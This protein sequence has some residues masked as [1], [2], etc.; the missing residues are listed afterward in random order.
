MSLKIRVFGWRN[1]PLD[2]ITRIEQ[3]FRELG[4][5]V[6][7]GDCDLI[8][9]HDSSQYEEAIK[10]LHCCSSKTKLF[11]KVLDVPAH[12]PNYD[13]EKTREILKQADKVLANSFFVQNQIQKYFNLD[14]Y[15]VYETA[16]QVPV[17]ENRGNR[18][19]FFFAGRACD[20]NKRFYLIKSV[21]NK[22][23]LSPNL[24]ATAGP[25]NPG[26]GQYFGIVTDEL[27]F[28]LYNNSYFTALPS[29]VEGVGLP[30][31]EAVMCERIPIV[32]NDNLTALELLPAEFCV[33][34]TTEAIAEY[35]T[36]LYENPL[37]YVF[38][39]KRIKNEIAPV[40]RQKFSP[41]SAATRILDAYYQTNSTL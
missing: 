16:K 23:N 41:R 4:H 33:E 24:V 10:C 30:M 38:L 7:N 21:I 39:Q 9:C 37:E 29:K 13:Y 26:Y 12:N 31:V 34:P 20:S 8:Y 40:F 15:V 19:L 36:K 14:S 28:W 17:L 32:C 5:F 22:L 27:L 3:G 2:Q 18:F 11:L 35:V 1:P 6:V 25:E